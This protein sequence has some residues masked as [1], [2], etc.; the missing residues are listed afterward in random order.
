MSEP[1]EA[2]A[3]AAGPDPKTRFSDRVD[4]YA[5]HRPT[6]PPG[7]VDFLRSAGLLRPGM[8]VADVGSGTGISSALFLAAGC[9]VYGVEPNAAMRA[10][11]EQLGRRDGP[12][13]H[14]IA[15]SAEATTLPAASVD[16]VVAGQA[17]HWFDRSAAK[18]EFARI[19]RP[20]G[21]AALFWNTRRLTGSAFAEGYEALLR[22]FGT[23][24]DRVRHDRINAAAIAEFFAPFPV[25]SAAFPFAQR[26]DYAGLEGRLLSSSYAPG[27]GHPRHRPMLYALRQVFDACATAGAVVMEYET[28]VYAG[29]IRG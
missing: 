14:S 20:G 28:E 25:R 26:F 15:G 27:P 12:A 23:D 1:M 24:Y 6:Y 11:A 29:R 18:A 2:P 16:L 4:A 9:T 13:F 22:E 7:V 10:V 19:L 5:R 21:G 8:T 3:A 17:F